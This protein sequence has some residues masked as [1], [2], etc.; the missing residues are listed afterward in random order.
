M[1]KQ[2]IKVLAFLAV[3]GTT[4][5][6]CTLL[7][8]L[9]YNVTPCPLEMHGDSVSVTVD[10][11]FPEKGI[12]K[13]ASAEITPMI[14]ETALKPVTFMG[15][16]ATGNG[17]VIQYKP[18]G[19]YT[20][21]DVVAYK[22]AMENTELMI[23]GTVSK[24]GKVKDEIDPIEICKGTIVTPL[25]VEKSG[26]V[27]LADDKFERV[28]P[29]T[30]EATINYM[31][32]K[33]NVRSSEMKD[34]DIVAAQEWLAAAET[35]AKINIKSINVTGHASPEGEVADNS[36]L[37]DNRATAGKEAMMGVAKKA[38]NTKASSADIYS[39]SGSG[40]DFPGFEKVLGMD[41]E[42]NADDKA[43]VLRVI[44]MNSSP[45]QREEELRNM[46]AT[47][48]YLDKNI[49]PLLR[50]SEIVTSYDLTGFSDEELKNYSVSNSDTLNL[51]ELL[52]CAT[53]YEDLNEK[54]R[55]YKI[56]EGRYA[57]DH[58]PSNN[59]GAVLYMQNKISEAKGK[60]EKANGIK[61]N[62]ISKNNLGA[63]AIVEGDR[64]KA[65]NLLNQAG[66]SSETSYNKGVL[67]IQDGDYSD[68]VSNLGSDASYNKALAQLL[69][70]NASAA[71][72]TIDN[73]VDKKSGQGYYLK[74]IAAARQDQLNEV[75]S[76]LKS[77]IAK[78]GSYKAKAMKD[79]EFASYAENAAF[80]AIVK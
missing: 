48:T 42:M 74:A 17:N 21:T 38:E 32:G 44:K 73:S 3:A 39:T 76:N 6:S 30:A 72:G 65:W 40:E 80:T 53:L 57:D 28:T 79:M 69:N 15:E 36:E 43:L 54:L 67:N 25:L 75:V 26:Q 50:R 49:F 8:D 51:E 63:V 20:Y 18:G 62:E 78:D 77:A 35:N 19:K 34:D 52:F 31:K 47:F 13:K 56:A 16:K 37:S 45:E 4:V 46:R 23:T 24:A 58:R 14:G 64:E 1:K 68:A 29:Q 10:I 70:G 7:K 66:S 9:E 60:F 2:S 33:S 27:I 5:S 71:V 12:N 41:T 11:T 22:P 61:D 59:V 55:V